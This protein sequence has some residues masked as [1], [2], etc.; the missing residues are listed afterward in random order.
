MSAAAATTSPDLPSPTGPHDRPHGAGPGLC[1]SSRTPRP[2]FRAGALLGALDRATQPYGLATTAGNVSHTGVGGLTLGGGM[3]W[4]ARQY[5]LAC[6]NVV[7]YTVVKSDG[8]LVRATADEHPDLI[9]VCAG[10]GNTA[11][12]SSSRSA[13]TTWAP[14]RCRRVHLPARSRRLP[15]CPA[16]ATWPRSFPRQA[17]LT[18]EISGGTVT[19]WLRVDREPGRGARPAARI[20]F[21]RCLAARGRAGASPTRASDARGR[22]RRPRRPALL[23]GAPSPRSC[24]TPPSRR[25]LT[26]TRPTP[27]RPVSASSPTAAR[28]P[29]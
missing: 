22:H 11:S 27:R 6:D 23:E 19:P 20:S 28:S 12:S 10:G 5:G 3:G 24:Q 26:A 21:D 7:S 14:E 18:D 8:D 17:T 25:S 9:G 29:S 1:R 13:C 16:G 4:L 2:E 15:R